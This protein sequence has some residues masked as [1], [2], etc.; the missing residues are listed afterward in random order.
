MTTKARKTPAVLTRGIFDE[1]RK[2]L[3]NAPDL[4][5]AQ[6]PISMRDG[7]AS[8]RETID[9]AKARGYSMER[10]AEVLRNAGLDITPATLATYARSGKRTRTSSK[11]RT[12]KKQPVTNTG[13]REPTVG[14]AELASFKHNPSRD[15]KELI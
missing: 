4:P 9:A 8:I 6:Q 5:P 2:A 11:P 15:K 1:A 10:I 13:T 7:I 14:K 12:P 3:E